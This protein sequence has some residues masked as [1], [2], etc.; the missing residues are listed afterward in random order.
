VILNK[1]LAAFPL[2]LDALIPHVATTASAK[3]GRKIHTLLTE[4]QIVHD[5]QLYVGALP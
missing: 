4:G 1:E 3:T 5:L 2:L